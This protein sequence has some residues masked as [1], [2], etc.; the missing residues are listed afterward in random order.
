MAETESQSDIVPGTVFTARQVRI[1]KRVVIAMG[2]LLVGGFVLIISVIIYQASNVGE[3]ADPVRAARM[4]ATAIVP[5]GSLRVPKGMAISH[6]A[7]DGNRLAVHLTGP[8]GAEIRI[9][10]LGTGAVIGTIRV[11]SE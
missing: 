4:P 1:L 10:D 2:A 6:L 3:S 5:Q 11:K 9:I 8:M 7:L